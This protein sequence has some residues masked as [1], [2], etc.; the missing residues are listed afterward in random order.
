MGMISAQKQQAH[1]D[2]AKAKLSVIKATLRPKSKAQ[3]E[4]DR[5]AE[6]LRRLL[7]DYPRFSALFDLWME[8]RKE[9]IKHLN[10]G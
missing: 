4:A 10:K 5:Q 6:R 2:K 7:T 9:Q 8:N 1:R 3:T